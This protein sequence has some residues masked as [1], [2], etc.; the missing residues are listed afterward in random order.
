MPPSS[1]NAVPLLVRFVN[2]VIVRPP[3]FL[4]GKADGGAGI[5]LPSKSA[6]P[7]VFLLLGVPKSN[8]RP[9]SRSIF[10]T[11]CECP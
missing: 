5:A 3:L 6:F 4:L 10:E 7:Y 11:L 8:S 9:S 2:G 1:L